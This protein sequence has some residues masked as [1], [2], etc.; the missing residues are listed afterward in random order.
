[1]TAIKLQAVLWE[2]IEKI[3]N[4]GDDP[5]ERKQA[6]EELEGIVK[7]A[8]SHINNSQVILQAAKLVKDEKRRSRA[9]KLV[10]GDTE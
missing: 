6:F 10:L 1:M 7:A 2:A 4:L 9:V 5:K 3:K 8:K